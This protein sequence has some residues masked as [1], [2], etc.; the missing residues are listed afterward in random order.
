MTALKRLRRSISFRLGSYR[1]VQR[2]L[3]RARRDRYERQVAAFLRDGSGRAGRLPAGIV[4]ETT[5]RCNLKC[6]FC[7][8]GELLNIEGEWRQELTLDALRRAFP[9]HDG[10]QVSL[11][12]GEVF[13]RK[14]ILEVLDLFRAKGY[15]CGY[16]TT[17]GTI[18]DE[19]RAAALA[20]LAAA[21]FLTHVTVSID[22]PAGLHDR[23]RGVAGTFTRAAAGL[24]RLQAAAR[25]RGAPLRVSIN[26]TV[27]RESLAALDGM[28]DVATDLGVD[29]IGLNHLMYA[30]PDEVAQT[31]IDV[32]EPGTRTL[33]TARKRGCRGIGPAK[34]VAD[35]GLFTPY[36]A[37]RA[38]R[39]IPPGW[40]ID[41]RVVHGLVWRP[42]VGIGRPGPV[43]IDHVNAGLR[44]AGQR[45]VT[46]HP[47]TLEILSKRRAGDHRTG[48]AT[49]VCTGGKGEKPLVLAVTCRIGLIPAEQRYG[50]WQHGQIDVTRPIVGRHGPILV[51]H[52][53]GA[54]IVIGT[55]A[56]PVEVILPEY[57]HDLSAVWLGASPIRL[58]VND[59]N[60][61]ALFVT[62]PLDLKVAQ[63]R[64]DLSRGRRQGRRN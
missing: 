56:Y 43:I 64:G 15:R 46:I 42:R 57:E 26:A 7:Y 23:A 40:W 3:A 21:G 32:V 19:Q 34:L 20:S 33:S 63:A 41:T 62:I 11:T 52:G 10:L 36:F 59:L 24:R 45:I 29:A 47:P 25:D 5:M 8:V 58:V 50:R 61:V 1:F 44:L 22:G 2:A 16:L 51:T 49:I 60:P 14:D 13:V 39:L 6:E 48:T 30:T 37:N 9:E 35:A 27:A 31:V 28:V 55:L 12:G 4:Y 54:R 18:I 17:N 38:C 53:V